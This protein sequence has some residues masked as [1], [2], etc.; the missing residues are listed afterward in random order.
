M[1]YI[2]LLS[3]VMMRI[4]VSEDQV[5]IAFVWYDSFKAKKDAVVQHF[6]R[7]SV[8]SFQSRASSF[9]NQA[10]AQVLVG[11][12]LKV[13][14][15]LFQRAAGVFESL[16]HDIES[17]PQAADDLRGDALGMLAA[18]QLAQAQECFFLK[19][20]ESKMKPAI[21]SKLCQQTADYFDTACS[22]DGVRLAQAARRRRLACAAA[23]QGGHV[24]RADA[25]LSRRRRV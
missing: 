15:A 9:A 16:K 5:R 21:L 17:H 18:L 1:K 19:A 10:A 24:R 12:G 11:D 14:A 22:A 4:P 7:A 23:P 2:G 25:G 6:L 20:A 3:S 13:A 8:R